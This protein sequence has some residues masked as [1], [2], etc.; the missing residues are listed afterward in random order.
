MSQC[1]RPRQVGCLEAPNHKEIHVSFIW[2][3]L[4]DKKHESHIIFFFG[5]GVL[6]SVCKSIYILITKMKTIY[7]ANIQRRTPF[8]NKQHK[9][10]NLS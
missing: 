6:S 8:K 3:L 7:L 4:L 2:L 5:I 9:I 1:V 10:G